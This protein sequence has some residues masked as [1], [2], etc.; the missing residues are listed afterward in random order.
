[1]TKKIN[2]PILARVEGEGALDFKIQSN[3]VKDLKLRIYEP[4]RLFEKFLEGREPEE[5][6][7]AVA[8]IC[9]ICPVAYQ[10]SASQALEHIFG[11]EPTPWI[12]AMRRLFYCG[13]WIESHA[14][15]MHMLAL[16]D[17]LGYS[18]PFDMAT[19][20]PKIFE[21]GMKL[22]AL[23]LDLMRL[24]GKRSVNPVGACIGGFHFSPTKEQVQALLKDFKKNINLAKSLFEWSLSLKYPQQSKFF[25]CVAMRNPY[26]YP[27]NEGDIISNEG[28]RINKKEFL[29]FFEEQQVD[30]STALHCYLKGKTYMVGPLA[31]VNLNYDHLPEDI[32]D[33]IDSSTGINFPSYNMYHSLAARAIEI[34]Y[35][36]QEAIQ[37]MQAYTSDK[38]PKLGY[39]VNPGTGFGCTEAPRGV[40]W[41]QYRVDDKG[42]IASSRIIPPTSQ[43]QAR[44]EEDLTWS[45]EQYA[46]SKNDED[47]RHFSEVIIRNYDPCIS[48]S[49]HFLKLN[50]SR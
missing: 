37:I 7:D 50:I 46:L 19:H 18:N 33:T 23:G 14:I 4:P 12:K 24:L 27:M 15:H 30:Y 40:L 43:N 28:L 44:I 42:L 49:T 29:T 21:R 17:L 38:Q 41:H 1:M 13:E 47:L 6:I 10:M 11:I 22:H 31:R 8:R 34:Y 48:C 25:T 45:I 35:A 2:I 26:E 5:V 32:Q 3:K 16:P 20:H 9:G 36:F 39:E